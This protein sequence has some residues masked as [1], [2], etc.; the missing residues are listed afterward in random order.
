MTKNVTR[1]PDKSIALNLDLEEKDEKD[2]FPPF[3]IVLFEREMELIDPTDMDYR[4]LAAIDDA[5]DFSRFAFSLEDR[6]FLNDK[7]VPGWMFGRIF[8]K[9]NEHFGLTKRIAEARRIAERAARG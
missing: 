7:I 3:K 1:L 5:I 6:E 2:Q 4:D 8:D 9:Y